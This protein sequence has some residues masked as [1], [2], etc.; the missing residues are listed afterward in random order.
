MSCLKC[1]LVNRVA[2]VLVCLL[3]LLL[4]RYSGITRKILLPVKTKLADVQDKLKKLLP[5]DAILVGHSLN[6]DLQAL[7]V[8]VLLNAF[9]PL[10]LPAAFISKT[11]TIPWCIVIFYYYPPFPKIGLRLFKR[12]VLPIGMF[13]KHRSCKARKLY[14]RSASL[15]KIDWPVT[16]LL[17]SN[18]TNWSSKDTNSCFARNR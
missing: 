10:P 3:Q 18:Y 13:K 16:A 15:S 7:Q 4:W 11:K 6:A 17:S 2:N 9:S 1:F 14:F 12:D 8:S 5:H